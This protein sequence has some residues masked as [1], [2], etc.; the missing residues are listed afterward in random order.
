MVMRLSSVLALQLEI[1]PSIVSAVSAIVVFGA[2]LIEKKSLS[3]AGLMFPLITP[4]T[5]NASKP[6]AVPME[7]LGSRSQPVSDPQLDEQQS[8]SAVLP[9]SHCSP[10]ALMPSPQVVTQTLGV[11]AQV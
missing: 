1:T 10:P 7:S 9:S 8:P 4:L 3:P 6:L 11:P 5:L 2:T